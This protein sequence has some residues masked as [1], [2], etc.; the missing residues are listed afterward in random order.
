MKAQD[1]DMDMPH[2][3]GMWH[4]AGC[5]VN[6]KC[7]FQMPPAVIQCVGSFSRGTEGSCNCNCNCN[8]SSFICSRTI[9]RGTG[10]WEQRRM[11]GTLI[12]RLDS[13][14]NTSIFFFFLCLAHE[15]TRHS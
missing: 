2:D 15:Y 4:V 8:S 11:C 12:F 7:D 13:S 9:N 1:M 14:G 10:D 5:H 6:S 3:C